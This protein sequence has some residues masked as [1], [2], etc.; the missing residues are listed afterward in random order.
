MSVLAETA[1]TNNS[2]LFSNQKNQS[3]T[4]SFVGRYDMLNNQW[5]YGYWSTN[6]SFKVV[7]KVQN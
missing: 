4:V 1:A 6:T 2:T 3:N 5:I 7:C